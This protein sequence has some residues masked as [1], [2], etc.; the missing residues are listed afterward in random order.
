MIPYQLPTGKTVFIKA[1]SL[2]FMTDLEE[3]ELIANDVGCF[4]N[5]PF[6]HSSI[7]DDMDEEIYEISLEEIPEIEDEIDFD[8]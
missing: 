5:N 7:H 1:E 4:I 2:L 6:Y 3:Q 8:I